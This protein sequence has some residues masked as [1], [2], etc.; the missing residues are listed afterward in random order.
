LG[1]VGEASVV[2]AETPSQVTLVP[3]GTDDSA[4]AFALASIRDPDWVRI[5]LDRME[6]ASS[7]ESQLFAG[8]AEMFS[9]V[10]FEIVGVASIYRAEPSRLTA[11]LEVILVPDLA[12]SVTEAQ[13]IRAVALRAQDQGFKQLFTMSVVTSQPAIPD[14]WAMERVCEIPDLLL[15]DDL[16]WDVVVDRIAQRTSQNA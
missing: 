15:H 12:G 16:Y 9:V 5:H 10:A 6:C 8:V 13:C 7:F 3:F 4:F 11:W 14:G 1:V 2:S